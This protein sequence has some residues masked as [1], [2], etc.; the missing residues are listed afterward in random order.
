MLS[1]EVRIAA[2]DRINATGVRPANANGLRHPANGCRAISQF[3]TWGG[4]WW[5][6]LGC[7]TKRA[8]A[9]T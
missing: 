2:D 9:W 5:K 4:G 3:A 1:G 6:K 7:L 8:P